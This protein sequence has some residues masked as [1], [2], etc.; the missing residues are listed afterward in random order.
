VPAFH[1][2]ERNGLAVG[3]NFAT[4]LT[5]HELRTC[6]DLCRGHMEALYDASGYGWDE[7]LKVGHCSGIGASIRVLE[8]S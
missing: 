2:F 8:A 7:G 5:R 3:L 1:R 4:R 6:M